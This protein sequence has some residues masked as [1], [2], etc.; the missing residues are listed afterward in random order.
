M[1]S[2]V[3]ASLASARQSSKLPR[4]ISVRAPYAIVCAILPSATLPAGTKTSAGNSACAAYAASDA[5]AIAIQRATPIDRSG[6]RQ[7]GIASYYHRMFNGRKMA[8][9]ELF[10]FVLGLGGRDIT[11]AVIDEVIEQ[12]RAGS[13]PSREDLWVGVNP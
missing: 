1:P 5:Q 7:V 11:P 13:A 2:D 8:D 6:K 3:L 10:G 9:G 12:A 4:T